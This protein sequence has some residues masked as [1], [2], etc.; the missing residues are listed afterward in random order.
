MVPYKLKANRIFFVI[1]KLLTA[2]LLSTSLTR[3]L[4]FISNAAN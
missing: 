4:I 2:F 1:S 3:V